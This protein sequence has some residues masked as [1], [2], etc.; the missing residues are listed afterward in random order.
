MKGGR[1]CAVSKAAYL[2][3]PIPV[4]ATRDSLF[5]G[6]TLQHSLVLLSQ[7]VGS[8]LIDAWNGGAHSQ[9]DSPPHPSPTPWLLLSLFSSQ[10]LSV[11]AEVLGGGGTGHVPHVTVFVLA[12]GP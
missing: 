9:V 1:L 10:P 2:L 11:P 3:D 7:P 6:Q 12:V 5:P 8:A 4:S